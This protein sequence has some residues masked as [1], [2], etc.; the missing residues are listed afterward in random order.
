MK[1]VEQTGRLETQ[2]RVGV[3]NLSLKYAGWELRQG[4]YVSVWSQNSFFGKPQS[5]HLGFL[6]DWM[7][8]TH[9]IEGKPPYSNPDDLNA[10]H[11]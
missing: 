5:S 1:F 10:N 9:I 3:A 2:G 7:K 11:S 4:F 8:P 6:T